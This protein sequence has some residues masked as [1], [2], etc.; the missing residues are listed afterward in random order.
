M[1]IKEKPGQPLSTFMDFSVIHLAGQQLQPREGVFTH[2]S[3]KLFHY[4]EATVCF[5]KK[6]PGLCG[7]DCW[8][9]P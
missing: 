6:V 8:Y 7:S 1:V 9:Q 5:Q 3:P 4:K 2:F